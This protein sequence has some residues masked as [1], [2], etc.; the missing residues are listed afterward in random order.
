MKR[1]LDE[2]NGPLEERAARL[3]QQSGPLQ[4]SEHSFERVRRALNRPAPRRSASGAV[5]WAVVVFA[6]SAS[7]AALWGGAERGMFCFGPDASEAR[8]KKSEHLTQ[9]SPAVQAQA[10][11]SQPTN[12]ETI[13]PR[14]AMLHPASQAEPSPVSSPTPPAVQGGSKSAKTLPKRAE[15]ASD[16]ALVREAIEA[17]RNEKDPQRASE[18]LETYRAKGGKQ[19][20]GEEALA[21]SIE[22]AL[23]KDPRRAKAL[24]QEYQAK[25][26]NGRFREL[27]ARA[28]RKP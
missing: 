23:A 18:L 19:T 2:Q 25:Y 7:A 14:D 16:A 13:E 28:L 26:P 10:A 8:S 21:L 3:L 20:L 12:L 4:V 22:A 11:E 27:A 5:R 6:L 9:R 24:A 17:L 1:L 15:S